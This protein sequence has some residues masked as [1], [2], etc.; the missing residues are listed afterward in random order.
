MSEKENLDQVLKKFKTT[1]KWLL[2]DEADRRLK[3]FGYNEL[4]KRIRT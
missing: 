3:E 2:Q 4:K 1:G